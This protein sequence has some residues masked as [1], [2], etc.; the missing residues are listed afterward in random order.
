MKKIAVVATKK[1]YADF[2]TDNISKFLGR[3]AEFNSYSIPEVERQGEITEDFVLISAFNH[4][5]IRL[6]RCTMRG[7]VM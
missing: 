6:H 2:L 1:E 4:V 7:I 3:Y 5:C